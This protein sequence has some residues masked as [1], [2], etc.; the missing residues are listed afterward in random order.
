M[1]VGILMITYGN[2]GA[3]I[4][5]AATRVL[6]VCPLAT[7]TLSASEDCDP[8]QVFLEA[9]NSLLKLD[10]GDGVL[11]LTDLY[12]STPANIA[13]RLQQQHHVRV[14]AGLN[15]PMLVRLLNYPHLSLDE[16]AEKATSGG[17]DG[18]QECM[19]GET[20]THAK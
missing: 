18:I 3:V 15:L 10:H 12:G 14:V 8:E 5:Q 11:V 13:C 19:A 7:L 16:L 2:I 4:L 17:R 20:I 9:E 6:G 1:N